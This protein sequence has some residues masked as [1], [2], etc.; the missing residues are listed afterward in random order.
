MEDYAFLCI[1]ASRRNALDSC[2]RGSF[3]RRCRAARSWG[4]AVLR[5]KYG[6]AV[7]VGLWSS[8]LA[9]GACQVAAIIGSW[10]PWGVICGGSRSVELVCGAFGLTAEP[11]ASLVPVSR[12]AMGRVWCLDLGAERYAVRELFRESDEE[13]ARREAAFTAPDQLADRPCR[14]NPGGLTVPGGWP[15]WRQGPATGRPER[16]RETSGS[17]P[18]L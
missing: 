3:P 11:G 12:G 15:A 16:V 4:C 2:R 6:L 8:R 10:L 7:W 13:P 9:R 18:G 17:R 14:G 5:S 1:Y